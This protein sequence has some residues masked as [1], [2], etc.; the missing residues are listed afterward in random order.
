[1]TVLLM[2]VSQRKLWHG[3]W[4]MKAYVK[5]F[6]IGIVCYNKIEGGLG[7]SPIKMVISINYSWGGVNMCN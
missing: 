5:R 3:P 4:G 6:A 1:M 2:H 7:F